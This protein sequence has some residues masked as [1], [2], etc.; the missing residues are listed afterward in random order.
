VYT[1]VRSP[2]RPTTLADVALFYYKTDL[3]TTGA[4]ASNNVPTTSKDTASHQHMVT[5]TVG[6]GLDGQLSYRPDYETAGSGDFFDIKQG[7][8]KWPVPVADSP[9]ALDDLWHAAVNGRGVFFSAKN[10][11]ELANGLSETLN[12]LQARVGAGAAAATSNLQ[13]VAGDNFAFTA[14]YQTAAWIGD[15]KARTIDLSSGIVGQVQLWSAAGC[16]TA[17]F[18]APARSIRSTRR[19]AQA[20]A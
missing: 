6:L 17:S 11:E 3:R 12:Q 10:P 14:Q 7:T 1:T 18:S 5:F 20:M 13:P 19:I 9:T 15:V 4:V 8:K 2:A 16:W